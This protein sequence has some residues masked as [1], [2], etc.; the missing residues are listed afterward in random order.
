MIELTKIDEIANRLR[1]YEQDNKPRYFNLH[2]INKDF[3][4]PQQ[5]AERING[6]TEFRNRVNEAIN[7]Y[8]AEKIVV[9]EFNQKSKNV[10]EPVNVVEITIREKNSPYPPVILEKQVKP[11]TEPTQIGN[12]FE[13][14]GGLEGFKQEIR[15]EIAKEYQLLK[16]QEEKKKLIEENVLLKKE[17]DDLTVDNTQLFELNQELSEKIQ[18]LQKFVP[19]NLKIGDLSLTKV[20]GSV[21]GTA[22]ETIV[23]NIVTKKPERVKE[24]LGDTAFEQLSGLL[25][26]QQEEEF[27]ETQI[28]QPVQELQTV[29]SE[30]GQEDRH[31]LV[32][33]AIHEL[34]TKIT[35]QQ[36][37]KIQLIYYHFLNEDETI[38][39]DKLNEILNF[40]NNQKQ[41]DD[42]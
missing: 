23:K 31:A 7:V 33:D 1:R 3:P 35:S 18:A 41:S 2:Y 11:S 10:K 15:G 28:Q 17:N 19:E 13:A 30:E 21:L 12:P 32:A 5:I 38:N 37:G 27:D 20:I 40:I 36:L 34:N 42:E 29:P 9:E 14:Y 22:T 39:E 24:I 26:D 25:D 16:E 4:E 8:S 6:E